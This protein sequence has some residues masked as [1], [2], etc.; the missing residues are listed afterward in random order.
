MQ[1]IFLVGAKS[2]G[3]YG[4][5]ETFVYKLTQYHQDLSDLQYHVACK[6][7]G[8]GCMD[9]SK[10]SG[11]R[12]ISDSEFEFYHAHCFK[13]H[14]PQIGPAQAIYYDVAALW[15]CC[16]YIKKHQIKH[17]IIYIMTCRIGPF[18]RYFYQQI[19]KL[20]GKIYLN[21]D[22]H[23]WLR[24]KWAPPIRKYWKLSEHLMVRYAD[25]IVCDSIHI[26][27]Y[28]QKEYQKFH[29][30][31]TYLSYGAEVKPSF[32]TDDA[33]PYQEFLQKFA[34]TPNQY[35]L[36]VCRFVPENNFETIL[37]EFMRSHT[38]RK[39]AVITNTSAKFFHE[40]EEKLQF[41]RDPRIVFTGVVY[42][43]PLLHKLR[44]NAYAY[45]HGHEVGGT[46]PSLLEG[47]GASKLNLLFDVS[48]NR[49]VALDTA[50]YWTKEPG[51]LAACIEKA[52]AMSSAERDRMGEKAKERIRSAYSWTQIANQYEALWK[53]G[54]KEKG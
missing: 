39:L 25:L 48:F 11:A 15:K 41:S 6:A 1:H 22:G 19:H 5:Y 34:L 33:K 12:R 30:K 20:G 8:D 53:S 54:C 50:L 52:E 51:N 18:A 29:P 26:E 47:L 40:L 31:T 23:E 4:G 44:E 32:L 3:N 16:Q 27:S 35:Y 21:P 28:I 49:E 2:L 17:P 36:I 13:I 14:V 43:P 45:L 42:N 24:Q 9:E 46:N 10:L 7:N 38:E 37:R